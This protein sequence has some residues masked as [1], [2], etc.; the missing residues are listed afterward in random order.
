MLFGWS[1]L[2]NEYPFICIFISS[3]GM[4]KSKIVLDRHTKSKLLVVIKASINS[5]LIKSLEATP[6]KFQRRNLMLDDLL[7]PGLT[8]ISP[9]NKSKCKFFYK[10]HNS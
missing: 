8:S 9:D 4:V 1:A 10:K 7:R 2:S 3:S 6:R 5:T